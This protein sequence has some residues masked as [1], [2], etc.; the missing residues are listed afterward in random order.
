VGALIAEAADLA[1]A[2]G[3]VRSGLP[4]GEVE[5]TLTAALADEELARVVRAGRLLKSGTYDGFGEAWQPDLHVLEGGAPKAPAPVTS[6]AKARPVQLVR[7]PALTAKL[8]AK[9]TSKPTSEPV[10]P[11]K[12]MEEDLRL[13]EATAEVSTAE[14]DYAAAVA[15]VE[16]RSREV[17]EIEE[18]LARLRKD[19]QSAHSALLA[20][21][22]AGDAAD[23]RL[24][25]A[26]R[27]LAAARRAA[28]RHS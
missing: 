9:P 18:Q 19:R 22:A 7:E 17:G 21:N 5:T 16:E 2:A 12:P 26:Q 27:R 1:V 25:Q 20:A 13:A 11:S 10:Q 14:A 8:T 28:A 24:Q 23:A 4:V 3:A 15:A 6:P